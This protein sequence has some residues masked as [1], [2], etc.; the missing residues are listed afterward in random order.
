MGVNRSRPTLAKI[1]DSTIPQPGLATSSD[2]EDFADSLLDE[3]KHR[4]IEFAKSAIRESLNI[5]DVYPHGR[6]ASSKLQSISNS[7][8]DDLNKEKRPQRLLFERFNYS[9]MSW[10]QIRLG[11]NTNWVNID[12]W[13]PIPGEQFDS[14][15]VDLIPD[16]ISLS[17]Q[18]WM[19]T[20][21]S[22]VAP[23]LSWTH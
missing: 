10:V 13:V 5:I 17:Y 15:L 9:H 8:H 14:W 6:E 4:D 18:L 16:G 20:L 12:D 11:A 21:S 19:L 22:L 7:L 1:L 3:C 23:D 2:F